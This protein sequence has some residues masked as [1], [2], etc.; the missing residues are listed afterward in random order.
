VGIIGS[1]NFTRNGLTYNTELNSV[2]A[3]H[4]IV[5]FQTQTKEQEVGHLYWFDQLRNDPDTEDWQG[6]FIELLEESPVGDVLFSPYETYIRTLYELYKEELDEIELGENRN[7]AYELFGISETECSASF[8]EAG[9]IQCRDA[10]G[11]RWAWKDDYG[12]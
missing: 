10:F 3:D 1:S 2:E 6:K 11:F 8:E 12:Y 7:S 5:T 9:Q 4:R